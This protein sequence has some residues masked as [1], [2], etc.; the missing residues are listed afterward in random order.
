MS[1]ICEPMQKFNLY[2]TLVYIFVFF[3]QVIMRMGSVF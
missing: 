1:E 2:I 3:D